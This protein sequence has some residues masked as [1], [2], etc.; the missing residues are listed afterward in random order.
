MRRK[1]DADFRILLN[2]LNDDSVKSI[3]ESSEFLKEIGKTLLNAKMKTDKKVLAELRKP[4][5]SLPE[6]IW[7]L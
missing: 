3:I 6:E 4:V 1:I 5:C 7:E 2:E